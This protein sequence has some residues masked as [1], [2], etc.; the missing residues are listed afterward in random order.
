[1][2]RLFTATQVF[3][4]IVDTRQ[5]YEAAQRLKLS[6][7]RVTRYV[8]DLES[9]LGVKLLQRS[10]HRTALTDV[11]AQYARGCRSLLSKPKVEASATL[12]STQIAGELRVAI[13]TR[14]ETK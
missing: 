8:D 10:T 4:K 2:N 7:A 12:A 6:P 3:P 11:G 9:R 1:M 13:L 5:F 14:N